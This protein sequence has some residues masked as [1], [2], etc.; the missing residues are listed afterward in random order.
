MDS[1]RCNVQDY[2]ASEA[3][4]RTMTHLRLFTSLQ[5]RADVRRVPRPP[6]GGA[7]VND[8]WHCR[9]ALGWYSRERRGKC[10]SSGVVTAAQAAVQRL[11]GLCHR[12]KSRNHS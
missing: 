7:L 4:Y 11:M 3:V 5:R 8:C 12:L 6:A 9:E 1:L 10:T 2:D